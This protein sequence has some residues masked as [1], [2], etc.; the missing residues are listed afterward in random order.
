MSVY[1]A[2]IRSVLEYASQVWHFS[3]PQHL[4]DQIEQVQLW[5]LRI[6]VPYMSYSDG[7][8]AMNIQTLNQRRQ[9]HYH[10]LYKNILFRKIIN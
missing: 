7:I 10:K 2:F 6:A 3:I 5:A 9:D 8:E 4:N 1:S